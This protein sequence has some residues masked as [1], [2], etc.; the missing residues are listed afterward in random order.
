MSVLEYLCLVCVISTII[1]H[2]N[3]VAVFLAVKVVK[4]RCFSVYSQPDTDI[5]V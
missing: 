3:N 1:K 2:L 4:W 5:N